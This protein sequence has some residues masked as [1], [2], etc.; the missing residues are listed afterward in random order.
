MARRPFADE[1]I[2]LYNWSR[3]GKHED[4]VYLSKANQFKL[5]QK[6]ALME[7]KIMLKKDLEF[8]K[9]F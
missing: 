4:K 5:F 8:L 1:A 9:S 7:P 6:V 2:G 3:Y